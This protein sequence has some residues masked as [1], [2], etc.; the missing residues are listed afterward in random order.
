VASSAEASA[1]T[2]EAAIAAAAAKL[3][4]QEDQ[5]EVEVLKQ[6]VPSTFGKVGEPAMVRV[7]GKG[8]D[9]AS[10]EGAS[11]PPPAAEPQSPSGMTPT[12]MD[13]V[14]VVAEREPRR[15]PGP[16]HRHPE[17]T[18]PEVVAADTELAAD[19]VEG[20]LDV[21]DV[22]GD[23]TTWVDSAGGHV[24]VEG[25]KLDFIVGQEGEA[26]AALQELT[27]LAVLRRTQRWVRITIDV[28]GFKAQ[29][30][31]ELATLARSTAEHVAQSGQAEEFEPMTAFDRKTVHDVVATVGG[32]VSESVGEEPN[33]RVIIRRESGVSGE[34]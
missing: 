31:E 17:V 34:A 2:V 13:D 4:L 33:R 32:V 29:R 28:N 15:S 27:R 6:A 11:P 1:R 5:I 20:L 10:S 23:I 9:V 25:P 16:S 3:G 30:R 7:R 26:L 24:D 14:G 22:D 21:L 8:P 19:F 18:D 12:G